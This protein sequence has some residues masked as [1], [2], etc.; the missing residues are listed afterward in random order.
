K[1]EQLVLD[2]GAAEGAAVLSPQGLRQKPSRE[3]VFLLISERITRLVGVAAAEAKGRSVNGVAAR[4]GLRSH[5]TGDG[6]AKLRIVVLAGDFRF[7][8][9]LER[10]IDDNNSQ[11]GVAILGTCEQ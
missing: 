5:H 8:D 10:R 4:F 9:R 1:N 2:D 7:R 11:Y 6:L 3:T